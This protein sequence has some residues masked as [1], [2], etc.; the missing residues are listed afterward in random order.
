M[1]SIPADL[2]R[3]DNSDPLGTRVPMRSSASN[4]LP[5]GPCRSRPAT[6]PDPGA[7]QAPSDERPYSNDPP[8]LRTST[9]LTGS[10]VDW[11]TSRQSAEIVNIGEQTATDGPIEGSVSSCLLIRFDLHSRIGPATRS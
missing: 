8:V 7:S 4:R 1:L 3:E 9:A 10:A 5:I 6:F 2:I 11:E